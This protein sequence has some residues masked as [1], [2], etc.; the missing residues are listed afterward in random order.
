MREVLDAELDRR[1]HR[2]AHGLHAH[3]VPGRA[4][5]PALLGPAA[6]AVHD[7]G[8]VAR[9]RRARAARPR[10]IVLVH[11][12]GVMP[13]RHGADGVRRSAGPAVALRPPVDLR[14]A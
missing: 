5:Q 1:P 8:D 11:G 12:S 2:A 3:A 14:P 9:H 4:R 10:L 13:Q 7:D 6:V